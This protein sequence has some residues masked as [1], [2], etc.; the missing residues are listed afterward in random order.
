MRR[1][2]HRTLAL[3]PKCGKNLVGLYANNQ[4]GA[5]GKVEGF[6]FCRK[7]RKVFVINLKVVEGLK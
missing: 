2:P 6:G 1:H 3:C 4:N 7:C 5:M